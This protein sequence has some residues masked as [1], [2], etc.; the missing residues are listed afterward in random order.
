MLL[1]FAKKFT[2]LL[3]LQCES[4]SHRNVISLKEMPSKLFFLLLCLISLSLTACRGPSGVCLD[5]DPGCS[6]WAWI[7]YQRH[8][9]EISNSR[10]NHTLRLFPDGVIRSWG[11]N[12]NG[13]LGRNSQNNVGDGVGLS[14]MEAGNV[15]L[16]SAAFHV[17]AGH[18]FSCAILSGSRLRCWGFNADGQLGK[19]DT[20]NVSDGI[21]PD[22][23]TITDVP[24][25]VGVSQIAP[26]ALH[27][28]ALLTDGQV[29]CWGSGATGRLGYGDTNN[30][31][32][33]VG[34]SIQAKGN[35]PVD[36]TRTVIQIATGSDHTCALLSDGQVRC[37][38]PGTNGML[39]YDSTSDVGSG[40]AP[41][42]NI[43]DAGD[44]PVGGRVIQ[45][46][47]GTTHSCA[48]LST[49]AVRCWGSGAGGKLGHDSVANIGDGVGQTIATA[50]D[51]PLGGTA[52]QITAGPN[53]TCALLTTGAIRC[54]GMGTLGRLGYNNTAN[55]GDGGT[56]II[57]AGDVPV[58]GKAVLVS[59]GGGFTCAVLDTGVTRCWGDGSQGN[60]GHNNTTNIGD[61]I[62][63]SIID[64]GDVPIR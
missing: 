46:S 49:G 28:C 8:Y 27:N 14:I 7:L 41:F 35:V 54:W 33:G 50:G 38:G 63:P 51:I 40:A 9:G 34:V 31:G 13:R 26:S 25:G 15:N 24:V 12:S 55:V 52:V 20:V 57:Q 5:L 60:L 17:A 4:S 21:G 18:Q 48:L 3:A 11:P 6:N 53:H 2:F 10:D 23:E 61:G 58:G 1:S 62:G 56:S 64:A 45:L 30:V 39:G 44:V 16:G 22:I 29:R 37:W 47:L 59:V 43:S 42:N 32:N 36:S 19:N